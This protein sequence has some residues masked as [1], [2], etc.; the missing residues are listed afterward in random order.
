MFH[1]DIV[2][3]RGWYFGYL[4]AVVAALLAFS[5]HFI[6]AGSIGDVTLVLLFVG[7]VL[8]SSALGGVGPSLAATALSAGL[9][10]VLLAGYGRGSGGG[11]VA[12][13]AVGTAIALCG[14]WLQRVRQDA[15][16]A[17]AEASAQEAHLRSIL[18]TVPDAMIVID[19]SG[20]MQSFSS[21][22][23]RLFGY[24]ATEAIGKNVSILMPNPYREG[25]DGYL[26]RYRITGERRVIGIGRV[27]VGERR[28]G[29]TF[30]IELAVGEMQSG[31]QRF[32]TGFIR[33]LSERQQTEARLQELQSELVHISRLTAMGELASTLAHELNQ[34]LSAIANYLKGSHRL[35]AERTD[36]QSM[37]VGEA[38]DKAAD[39]ALR[40]GE[41]IRRLRD[42][43]ARGDTRD[44]GG[45]PDQARG[46][47]ERAGD[48]RR[49]A[50]WRSRALPA[51]PERRPRLRRQDPGAAGLP[52]PPAQRHR[53]DG[54]SGL[55]AA[56]DRRRLGASRRRH[57]GGE[58]LRHR[59]GHLAGGGGAAFPAL[60]HDEAAGHGR[61][62]VDLAHHY[63]IAWRRALG[64]AQSRRRH[65]LP[66]DAPR[67]QRSCA[68]PGDVYVCVIDDDDAMRD[69]LAFL[70]DSAGIATRTCESAQAFVAA[71]PEEPPACVLTDVRMPG[72]S[73]VDLLRHLRQA[74]NDVPVIVITGHGDISLAVE[75]M[76]LGAVDF[77]EKPF[78]D[79][80]LLAAVRTALKRRTSG[81]EAGAERAAVAARL[82]TLSAR[83][84]QVLDGLISGNP[85]KTIAH[86][87]RDQPAHGR[88]LPCEPDGQDAGGEPV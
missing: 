27:V 17:T 26:E 66:P 3:S 21:A 82:A 25:H 56:R 9:G 58:R 32:F 12:F 75:A 7:A 79:E 4:I 85:N 52:Q 68:M 41:I 23:E 81:E 19:E 31:E 11:I 8:V 18:D 20:T 35:I 87:A 22:A 14:G 69:S 38:L 55:A 61:R 70:L 62:S 59:P 49:Q 72:M 78:Q 54:G 40:A 44:Q 10:V 37:R 47:S 24:S 73:G 6:F 65:R 83:E 45:E 13:A 1:P 48:G 2:R 28:D 46:G 80:V 43:V 36:A 63:R 5:T 29:S 34:P 51:R 60:R 50:A 16:R 71:P 33:D 42:F 39:Q 88:G 74:G 30:P 86:D 64:R 53:G 84:R 15:A 76:K 77:I 57:G 67:R